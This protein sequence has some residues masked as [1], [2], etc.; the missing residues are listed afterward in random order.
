MA[1]RV[2]RLCSEVSR[3]PFLKDP[4]ARLPPDWVGPDR[5]CERQVWIITKSILAGFIRIMMSTQLSCKGTFFLPFNSSGTT[6]T[7]ACGFD[8]DPSLTCG[9]KLG[10]ISVAIYLNF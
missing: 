4:N 3:I 1:S 7:G 9:L 2:L 6:T 8:L 10:Q 5:P